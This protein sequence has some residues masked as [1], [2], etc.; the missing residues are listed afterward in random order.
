M[1]YPVQIRFMGKLI[2]DMDRD[3]LLEAVKHCVQELETCRKERLK[4]AP[5]IDWLAYFRRPSEETNQT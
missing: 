1:P 5:F 3:E 2:E 4:T